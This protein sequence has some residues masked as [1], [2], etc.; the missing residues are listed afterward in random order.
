LSSLPAK[1]I[2]ATHLLTTILATSA[3]VRLASPQHSVGQ[4]TLSLQ[5]IPDGEIIVVDSSWLSDD[6]TSETTILIEGDLEVIVPVPI[7]TDPPPGFDGYGS[8]IVQQSLPFLLSEF[9]VDDG[10]IQALVD[11]FIPLGRDAII[12]AISGPGGVA[13][14]G[15]FGDIFAWAEKVVSKAANIVA[16]GAVDVTCGVVAAGGLPLYEAANILFMAQNTGTVSAP[17]TN[18]Q[19]FFIFPLH[20]L[21][22]HDDSIEIY[23]DSSF[24]VGFGDADGVTMGRRIYTNKP[25]SS[26]S[27]GDAGFRGTTRLLLHEFT[28]SKQYQSHNYNTFAFGVQYLFNWCKVGLSIE[29]ILRPIG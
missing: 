22:S 14:E 25:A 4:N 15:I 18:D 8:D 2:M 24:V 21:I 26:A 10:E 6:S 1:N 13:T 23:Y 3:L 19:D 5:E 9:G 29:Y 12:D 16:S 7:D 20:G 27:V 17:T 28:H 11:E